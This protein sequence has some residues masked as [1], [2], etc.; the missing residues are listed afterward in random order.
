[1]RE[2]FRVYYT[3]VKRETGERVVDIQI[4]FSKE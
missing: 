1:M 4:D 3:H 2:T